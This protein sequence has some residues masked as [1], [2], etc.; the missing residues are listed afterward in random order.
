MKLSSFILA[1]VF[2]MAGFS[3][4]YAENTGEKA[5]KTTTLSGKVVDKANQEALVGV[6]VRIEGLD[7]ET[8]T[9]FEGNFSFSGIIPDTYKVKCSM[10]SYNDQEIEIDGKIKKL[11]IKLENFTSK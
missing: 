8:Y 6:L 5:P 3:S 1:V 7:I 11:E 10:I 2:I 4:I 9:D